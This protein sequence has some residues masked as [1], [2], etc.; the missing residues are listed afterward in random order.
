MNKNLVFCWLPYGDEKLASS[1]LRVYRIHR[2]LL[3]RGISSTI[4][5]T[6]SANVAIIQK[7]ID[8][9]AFIFAL[10]AKI[11]G[12]TLVYDLDDLQNEI[13]KWQRGRHFL[14]LCQIS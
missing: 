11:K 7:R 8:R 2:E 1:R 4:G 3:R 5:F 12:M 13:G 14:F 6:S 10:K 9:S